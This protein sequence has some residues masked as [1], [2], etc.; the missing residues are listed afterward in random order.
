MASS[1]YPSTELVL[2]A[3]VHK[4]VKYLGQICTADA[5]AVDAMEE[6]VSREL[7]GVV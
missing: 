4:R 5:A 7:V 6:G 2:Q 1:L 3:A